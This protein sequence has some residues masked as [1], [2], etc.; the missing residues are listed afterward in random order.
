MG[1]GSPRTVVLDAGGLIAIERGDRRV[2]TLVMG[3]DAVHIAAGALAQTWRNPSRQARLARTVASD[4]VQ[5]HPLDAEEAQAAGR[6]CGSAGTTDV[7]DASVVLLTRRVDGVAV[8]SDPEDLRR[9][10]PGI[11]LAVC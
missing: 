7:I 9:L 2:V 4:L 5:V 6:L 8:T 11:R 1:T 3:A 10:D